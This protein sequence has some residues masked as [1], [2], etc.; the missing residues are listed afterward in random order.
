MSYIDAFVD[1]K[2]VLNVIEKDKN[3]KRILTKH[4]LIF[5]FYYEDPK[6]EFKSID[7]KKLSKRIFKN[8]FEMKEAKKAYGQVYESDL[9]ATS[10]TLYEHYRDKP[11]PALNV[12]FLDIE[13]DFDP[14]VGFAN[15][16]NPYAV[17][18]AIT[19]HKS[20]TDT[21]YTLAIPPKT[22][23][24]VD[25]QKIAKDIGNTKIFQTERELLTEFLD[26]IEDVD[27]LSGW[28]SSFFDISYLVL[29]IE[30]VLGSRYL[31]KMCLYGQKPQRKEAVKFNKTQFYYELS[32]RLHI[33]YLELY[34]K[35]TYSELHSFKLSNVGKHE[36]GEDKTSY[37]GTL[38]QLYNND[39]ELFLRYNRQ[40]VSILVKMERKLKFIDLINNLAHANSVL[41]ILCLGSVG[42][43]DTSITNFCHARNMK[44][45]DR[46][47]IKSTGKAAGAYVADPKKGMHKWI[48]STDIKSLYPSILRSLN[49]SPDTIYG[50]IRPT[51]T[52]PFIGHRALEAKSDAEAW[53]GVFATLESIKLK[54]NLLLILRVQKQNI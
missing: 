27:L 44:V 30:K 23:N 8:H 43:I 53:N 28:N 9:N 29:R 35:Y 34:R 5:S 14:K 18:N 6:G 38:D 49:M 12:G 36:I 25:A 26:L 13:V 47:G 17:V 22:L 7:G 39:F 16:N 21:Y 50:Q 37:E 19:V 42:L 46:R 40:D 52:N 20:N 24:W 54:Q 48:G 45:F 15:P 33:D 51:L 4:P 41:F 1:K 32:G 31:E 2:D 3:G 11:V 10:S